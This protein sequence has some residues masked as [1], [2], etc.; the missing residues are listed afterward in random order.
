MK[1]L[2][3]QI[4]LLSLVPFIGYVLKSYLAFDEA[5]SSDEQLKNR[6]VFTVSRPILISSP[7]QI[8]LLPSFLTDIVNNGTN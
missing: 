5:F 7:E 3:I 4:C 2:G 1:Y 6:L 8:L